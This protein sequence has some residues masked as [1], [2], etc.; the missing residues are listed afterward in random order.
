MASDEWGTPDWLMSKVNPFGLMID[1][2]ANVDNRKFHHF[3]GPGSPHG[4]DALAV[5][6]W[7]RPFGHELHARIWCNPPYSQG[8]GPI[9]RWYTHFK[10][11]AVQ[12][13][14]LVVFLVPATPAAVWCQELLRDSY[15]R[16]L[17]DG[18]IHHDRPPGVDEPKGG[19]RHD[20]QLVI[21]PGQLNQRIGI[22]PKERG[23][24]WR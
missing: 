2:A 11:Q 12:F 21:L 22:E 9:E 10:L 24:V 20:S 13:G 23:G 19:G 5:E 17:F 14:H 7:G 15:P 8:A 16:L 3:L 6:N 1:A 4:E 18:R